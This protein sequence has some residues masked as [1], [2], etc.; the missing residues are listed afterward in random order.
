MRTDSSKGVPKSLKV[1][2]KS[3]QLNIYV[4]K[5][6]TRQDTIYFFF[7]QF[8]EHE[9]LK[10]DKNME[11]F[12]KI[13]Y[14]PGDVAALRLSATLRKSSSIIY[15]RLPTSSTIQEGVNA[16]K[17]SKNSFKILGNCLFRFCWITDI[18]GT[19]LRTR[20]EILIIKH[21][22][23]KIWNETDR[24]Y[25][26]YLCVL[27]FWLMKNLTE[28]PHTWSTHISWFC[29]PRRY[30]WCWLFWCAMTSYWDHQQPPP[31]GAW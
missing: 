4:E 15:L 23:F 1:K 27:L 19:T 26:F 24:I 16:S 13:D 18:G 10:S 7:L 8:L 3:L 22:L 12:T 21:P 9:V 6:R 20:A 5:V 11:L 29:W 31:S 17:T 28:K 14:L 30:R 25:L 2:Y